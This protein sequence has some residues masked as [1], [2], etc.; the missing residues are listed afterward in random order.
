MECDA[1]APRGPRTEE[2]G[3][4]CAAMETQTSVLRR[5]SDQAPSG[6]YRCELCDFTCP[7]YY[8]T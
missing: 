3:C 5:V 4:D 8:L 7:C 2:A 6:Q 1:I